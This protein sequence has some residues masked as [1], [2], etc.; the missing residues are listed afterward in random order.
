MQQLM[1]DN[2][3]ATPMPSDDGY[4]PEAGA[5]RMSRMFPQ[6][7][8]KFTQICHNK[9]RSGAGL[10]WRLNLGPLKTCRRLHHIT[11]TSPSR[12]RRGQK[13]SRQASESVAK[14]GEGDDDEDVTIC[15]RRSVR[16]TGGVS[17]VA[18]RRRRLQY[19]GVCGEGEKDTVTDRNVRNR[20]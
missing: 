2:P 15:R 11:V 1:H 20:F 3:A 7:T 12:N 8:T 10:R 18:F 9:R 16:T 14:K 5:S 17:T 13:A 19:P 4:R 6:D